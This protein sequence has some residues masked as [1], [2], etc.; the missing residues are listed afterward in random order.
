MWDRTLHI[1]ISR[2]DESLRNSALHMPRLLHPYMAFT[3]KSKWL[4]GRGRREQPQDMFR[5]PLTAQGTVENTVLVAQ[6]PAA[7]CEDRRRNDS[8]RPA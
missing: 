5:P 3:I 4:S 2:R 8:L 7:R 1:G 6:I